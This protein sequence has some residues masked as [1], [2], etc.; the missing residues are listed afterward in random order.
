MSVSPLLKRHFSSLI[1]SSSRPLSGTPL[2]TTQL[3]SLGD[4]FITTTGAD[5]AGGAVPVKTSTG[6]RNNFLD[7]TR[8]F[9]EII[10][11]TG[12]KFSCHFCF[13]GSESCFTHSAQPII[14]DRKSTKKKLC[15]KDFAER[16]GELSGAICLKTLIL[17]GNDPVTDSNCSQE[18]CGAVRAICWLCGP[19]LATD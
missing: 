4:S 14:G 9:P 8:D 12:A 2:P 13:S 10:T 7:N 17:M 19:F 18:F 15:D 16:S 1:S 5:A 6:Y 3:L 11:S